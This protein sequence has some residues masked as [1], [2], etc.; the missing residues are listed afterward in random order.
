MEVSFLIHAISV[1][2]IYGNTAVF[3]YLFD[4]MY[5]S[6][7]THN[8]LQRSPNLIAAVLLHN[9]L[10]LN[11]IFITH[12]CLQYKSHICFQHCI[13]SHIF[14]TY[15][16]IYI[17]LSLSNLFFSLAGKSAPSN[18]HTRCLVGGK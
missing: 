7:I 9:V 10:T 11:S 16:Y 12:N 3:R 13:I 15:I 18:P 4:V 5:S 6:L 1:S 17:Y 14:N 2:K 8:L